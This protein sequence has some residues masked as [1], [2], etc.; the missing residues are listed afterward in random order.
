MISYAPAV[1]SECDIVLPPV[2]LPFSKWHLNGN[3]HNGPTM[4][5][6]IL[7]VSTLS[8]PWRPLSK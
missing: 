7:G 3:D 4:V 8:L 6:I 1:D 2:V 5:H